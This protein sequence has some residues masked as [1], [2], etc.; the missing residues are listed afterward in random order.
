M[1]AGLTSPGRTGEVLDTLHRHGWHA[2]V[3]LTG[4]WAAANPDLVRRIVAEG[5]EVANHTYDHPHLPTLS[6]GDI[7]AQ[8][9]RTEA[10]VRGIAGGRRSTCGRRLATTISGC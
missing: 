4:E 3:F 2:T 6:E 7:L 10:T 8:L 1:D 5:H 9:A